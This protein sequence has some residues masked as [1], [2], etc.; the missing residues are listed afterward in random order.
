MLVYVILKLG[1]MRKQV[2]F[3]SGVQ[4]PCE[5]ITC[6]FSLNIYIL[7]FLIFGSIKNGEK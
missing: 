7:I 4:D 1:K 2:F 5:Q 6:I 3:M